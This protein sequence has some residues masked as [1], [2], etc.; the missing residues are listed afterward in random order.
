MWNRARAKVRGDREPCRTNK[1][2]RRGAV[3]VSSGWG[4]TD[5]IDRLSCWLVGRLI[6]ISLDDANSF[7][8]DALPFF[9]SFILVAAP[10]QLK[11]TQHQCARASASSLQQM[12]AFP[13]YE[14][15]AREDQGTA[16]EVRARPRR[17]APTLAHFWR[18]F[19]SIVRALTMPKLRFDMPTLLTARC[20]VAQY[21]LADP[22]EGAPRKSLLPS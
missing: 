8:R 11:T 3:C 6:G 18:H 13:A 14:L 7:R 15:R 2:G 16:S 10:V 1:Q 17:R 12:R 19:G 20:V 5:R 9:C 22:P 21:V 4:S